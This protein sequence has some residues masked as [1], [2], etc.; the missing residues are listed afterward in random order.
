MYGHGLVSPI[1]RQSHLRQ[2]TI[3]FLPHF[4]IVQV[5]IYQKEAYLIFFSFSRNV[6]LP[7]L[8]VPLLSLVAHEL[9]FRTSDALSS[10][11]SSRKY[12]SFWETTESVTLRASLVPSLPFVCPSNCKIS[13]GI[14]TETMAEIPS[15][16]SEPSKFL[17]F[18][19]NKPVFLAYSL[20]TRVIAAFCTC[21]MCSA[22]FCPDVIDKRQNGFRIAITKLKCKFHFNTV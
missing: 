3:H 19:F 5:L 12:S 13:S 7:V 18:S 10:A 2:G 22:I 20:N 15:R 1:L 11:F 9:P 21:F 8:Y 14:R 17:S 4:S 6:H 16:I